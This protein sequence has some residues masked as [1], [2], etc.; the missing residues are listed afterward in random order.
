MPISSQENTC[1]EDCVGVKDLAIKEDRVLGASLCCIMPVSSQE[2]TCKGDCLEV[3]ELSIKGN[4]E[5]G[6]SL[7]LCNKP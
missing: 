1:K 7:H 3:K 2:N 4:E 6:A 5:I